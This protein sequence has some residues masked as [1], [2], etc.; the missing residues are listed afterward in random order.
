MPIITISREY[1]AGGFAVGRR[2]AELAGID[3]LDSA[4]IEEVAR[5]LRIPSETVERWGERREGLILRLLKALEAA[6]PEYAPVSPVSREALDDLPDPERIWSTVQE[7][8]REVARSRSAVIVGRGG[9]FVL[10]RWPGACHVRLVSPRDARIRRV[11]ERLNL[12]YA[13][14]ARSVDAADR[15][16]SAF[17]RHRFGPDAEDVHHYTLVLNTEALSLEQA[18]RIILQAAAEDAG[19]KG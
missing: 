15:E 3:F 13:E 16:R 11:A 12:A 2:V 5:R 10:A 6:H 19:R 8:M 7:V 1:G 9:A 14:A 17:L 4:L 18:A